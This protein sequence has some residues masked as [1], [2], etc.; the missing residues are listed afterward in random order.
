MSAPANI[1]LG[2][3]RNFLPDSINFYTPNKKFVESLSCCCDMKTDPDFF[4]LYWFC[5]E[6]FISMKIHVHAHHICSSYWWTYM[7]MSSISMNIPWK[8]ANAKLL[9]N[10][11]WFNRI[12][13]SLSIFKKSAWKERQFFVIK[14]LATNLF[15]WL[16][17]CVRIVS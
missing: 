13:N 14:H 4:I 3:L 5:S 11:D 7:F 6:S 2:E 16:V 17:N 1:E 15:R 12:F 9:G 10:V 8:F